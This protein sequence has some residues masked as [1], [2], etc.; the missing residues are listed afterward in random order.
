MTPSLRKQMYV[1]CVCAQVKKQGKSE[2]LFEVKQK[3]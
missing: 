1:L 2:A 3:W